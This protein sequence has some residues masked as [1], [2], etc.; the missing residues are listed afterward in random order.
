[1]PLVN[2]QA[3]FRVLICTPTGRDAPLVANYLSKGGIETC[4]CPDTDE[5][6]AAIATGAGV[7]IIAEEALTAGRIRS[8]VA[9]LDNQPVWS[10]FATLILTSKDLSDHESDRV[11]SGLG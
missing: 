10:D 1:M 4:V 3:P 9:A 7:A 8:L 6:C 2:V 5:L 11:Y